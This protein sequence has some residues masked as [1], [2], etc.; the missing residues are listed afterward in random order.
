MDDWALGMVSTLCCGMYAVPPKPWLPTAVCTNCEGLCQ[1][2][3]YAA[4]Q[5]GRCGV[6]AGKPCSLIDTCPSPLRSSSLPE[7]DPTMQLLVS[8]VLKQYCLALIRSFAHNSS[9]CS[10]L[11][12]N[13]CMT[14]SSIFRSSMPTIAH[15]RWQSS[16]LYD[17][18]ERGLLHSP[19]DMLH[20]S[21]ISDA[22]QSFHCFF[23]TVI[24]QDLRF[25]TLIQ[26]L[27]TS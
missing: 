25:F 9:R 5:H 17:I 6:E 15:G 19:L 22:E 24:L 12:S 23:E 20:K 10:S 2:R 3:P 21:P 26:Q 13:F 11:Q 27:P 14:I 1:E 4:P 18:G 8:C 16:T 7:C